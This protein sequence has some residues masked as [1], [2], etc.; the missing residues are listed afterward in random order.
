[1]ES[2]RLCGVYRLGRDF[3]ECCAFLLGG[4]SRVDHASAISRTGLEPCVKAKSE[5]G[6]DARQCCT[7]VVLLSRSHQIEWCFVPVRIGILL[8]LRR[9]IRRIEVIER[10]IEKVERPSILYTRHWTLDIVEVVE[11]ATSLL[12]GWWSA[13]R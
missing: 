1:M 11:A 5:F 8:V 13:V 12:G 7:T 2:V 10:M 6:D 9:S 3:A 4:Q